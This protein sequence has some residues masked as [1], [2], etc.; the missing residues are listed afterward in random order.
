[1]EM[2]HLVHIGLAN[3]LDLVFQYTML[4]NKLPP[5]SVTMPLRYLESLLYDKDGLGDTPL[6][7]SDIS[8]WE[9]GLTA[10]SPIL[11]IYLQ[12]HPETKF[13]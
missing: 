13:Y 7:L 9:N 5:D 8:K 12:I 3:V 4:H 2:P 6:N 1:M 11:R 10:E